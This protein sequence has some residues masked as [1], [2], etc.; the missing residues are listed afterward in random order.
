MHSRFAHKVTVSKVSG[1]SLV[2][3]LLALAGAFSEP[4]VLFLTT[5]EAALTV[6]EHRA[7]LAGK[8]R[9]RLPSHD[10]LVSLMHKTSFQQ[11]AERH[12]FPVPR[13]VRVEGLA[14]LDGLRGLRFPA[15]VK[16]T[17]KNADYVR[18]RFPRAYKVASRE[19][20]EA[21][22]R[23]VLSIVPGL[24]VQEWIDGS[25][26]DL[27]FCL[28][29]RGAD[30]AAV[31]SF[32]GRKLSIWPPDIGVTAS[33]TAAPDARPVLEPLT[34]AFFRRVS[35]V[36]M[37]G[38]EFKK[39]PRS[40]RFLMIEPTVGRVDAQEEVAT[41]HGANIPAAAYRYE[42]GLTVPRVEECTASAIWRDSWAH[43]RSARRRRFTLTPQPNARI[44]DA[45]WRID[46][47]M[48]GLFH[49]LGGSTRSLRNSVRSATER[50]PSRLSTGL[51]R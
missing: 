14:D 50:F 37:G 32:T 2:D 20:A 33:C 34:D 4:A 17:I 41:L 10:C 11:L 39:D 51:N 15:I 9:F 36:G 3:D 21:V 49:L 19:Q 29:Y 31:C 6:S 23:R 27:Y 26:S 47:P 5:D 46:D 48:P 12:G 44:F 28:Q 38:I 22:C 13:S 24:M 35:F 7:A 16:P 43:R 30:G 8:Y 1:P 40:G 42:V 18:G 25:D 45:Y